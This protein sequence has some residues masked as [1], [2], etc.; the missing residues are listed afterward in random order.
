M[1][2]A[3]LLAAALAVVTAQ[4]AAAATPPLVK[5]EVDRLVAAFLPPCPDPVN[6]TAEPLQVT[7]GS[8]LRASVLRVDSKNGWCATQVLALGTSTKTYFLG[9][10]WILAGLN[11]SPAERIRQFAWTRMQDTVEAK[12]AMAPRKDGFLPV[13]VEEKTEFGKI[14]VNGVVDAEATIFIPGDV[15]AL[16][17]D[18]ARTRLDTFKAIAAKAPA[19]GPA[20]AKVTVYE[21]S[22]FQCPACKRSATFGEKIAKEFGDKVRFVRIDLPLISSHPWAFPAAVAARA[23]WKQSPEAF[24]EFKN[25]LYENQEK[26]DAFKLEDFA[27]G[28]VKASGLD[29][30]RYNAD[31]ASAGVR[32]EILASISAARTAQ[33]NGTPSYLVDGNPV[34]PGEGGQALFAAIRK[35]AGAK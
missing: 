26:L 16:T 2:K 13:V 7:L 12:V 28:F 29:V 27:L 18:A 9:M 5:E 17:A 8:G 23:I 20:T 33:I 31:V 30:T 11:G 3:L 19:K 15:R 32:E 4:G 35:K 14:R 34:I 6:V 24:W 25:E 21:F 1:K 10:P 22:D